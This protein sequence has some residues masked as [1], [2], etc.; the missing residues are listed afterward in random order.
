MKFSNEQIAKLLHKA[1]LTAREIWGMELPFSVEKDDLSWF[2]RTDK[3]DDE[4][5]VT[6]SGELGA[7]L[8]GLIVG[9]TTSERGFNNQFEDEVDGIDHEED[10]EGN[11]I[12]E[13]E[14]DEL[15]EDLEDD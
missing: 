12:D 14:L 13:D 5:R 3:E 9:L 2:V 1:N 7:F 4:Y 8:S 11:E 15:D 6:T 10:Y